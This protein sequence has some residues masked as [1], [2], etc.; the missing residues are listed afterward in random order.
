MSCTR[1][2]A[3]L[4][5]LLPVPWRGSGIWGYLSLAQS[6]TIL[7]YLTLFLG[8]NLLYFDLDHTNC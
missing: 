8:L 4:Q 1:F 2:Q 6:V 3:E 7:T 5:H